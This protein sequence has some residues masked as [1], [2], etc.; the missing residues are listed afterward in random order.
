M[1]IATVLLLKHANF[2][3]FEPCREKMGLRIYANNKAS[4]EPARPLSLAR[5][6]DVCLKFDQGLLLLITNQ[7][8]P[9]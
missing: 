1:F 5:S 7:I 3:S 8:E 9:S 2:L 4:G 6:F